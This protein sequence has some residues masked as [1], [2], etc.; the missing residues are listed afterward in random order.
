[1]Y[2]NRSCQLEWLKSK[3]RILVSFSMK[4]ISVL[5]NRNIT[6]LKRSLSSYHHIGVFI[7]VCVCVCMCVCICMGVYL[8]MYVCVCVLCVY[9]CVCVCVCMCVC[10][11]VRVCVYICVQRVKER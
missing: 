1:M 3:T 9:I 6:A 7:C 11:S 2:L 5:K 8:C 10:V 4:E